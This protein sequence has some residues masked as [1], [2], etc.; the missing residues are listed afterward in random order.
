MLY[1]FQCLLFCT[2]PTDDSPSF[3]LAASR[4]S[5]HVF[6]AANGTLLSTWRSSQNQAVIPEFGKSIEE[7]SEDQDPSNRSSKR[8]KKA[9]PDNASDSSSAEIVTE[10]GPSRTR[11]SKKTK[12]TE[13]NVVNLVA[14]SDGQSI[15]VV[16]DEDKCVRVLRLDGKGRLQQLSQRQD[17]TFTPDEK[18]I[19]CGDKYGDVYAL[20]LNP[21]ENDTGHVSQSGAEP[22]EEHE[23]Q[24]TGSFP[25]ASTRTVHTL[26]NRQALKH[27]LDS[28]NKKPPPKTLA[29]NHQ[30]LLG[31]VSLLT[32]VKCIAVAGEESAHP[33]N[34]TFIITADRDEHIRISRGMPQAH[35][36]EG[37][38]LGHKHFVSKLCVP[39][40][41][42][43]LLI[44]GGGDDHLLVWDWTAGHLLHRVNLQSLVMN[45]I[46][47]RYASSELLNPDPIDQ[48]IVL[49]S[50][51]RIAV[52][53]L[54]PAE[55][56][57]AVG[58]LRRYIAVAVEGIPAVFLFSIADNGAMQQE[59]AIATEGNVISITVSKNRDHIAYA[60]DTEHK[61]FSQ[62]QLVDMDRPTPSASI[63][64]LSYSAMTGH[65]EHNVDLEQAIRLATPNLSSRASHV[66]Q[67][68]GGKMSSRDSASLLYGL[69]N[70]RKRG[71]DE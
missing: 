9:S 50:Y 61:Q 35:I 51:K 60:I 6:S 15:A 26:R 12:I 20:P 64:I 40:W 32:D 31:H 3:L 68:F 53:G 59:A 8:Q 49:A 23:A 67:A 58:E 46:N 30:L 7:R 55:A 34:R 14:T 1:P 16:T 2:L 21:A 71:Q 43:R 29:F 33:P 54:Y 65:W 69:E 24:A 27:Q 48:K 62:S 5:V 56:R 17:F 70:L 10:D 37:F 25:S 28:A 13:S 11:K 22:D 18:T 63:G 66:D 19:L 39:S 44:S 41:N 42:T 36:I 52:C 47:Y 45:H 4:A 57:N 38:C